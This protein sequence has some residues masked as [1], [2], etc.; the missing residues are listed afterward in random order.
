MNSIPLGPRYPNPVESGPPLPYPAPRGGCLYDGWGLEKYDD[1]NLKL[2]IC[3]FS[4]NL[5]GSWSQNLGDQYTAD[6]KVPK[7]W[8]CDHGPNGSYTYEN[9]YSPYSGSNKK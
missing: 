6:F 7:I 1:K 9:V 4:S 5:D 8:G 2:E 3:A